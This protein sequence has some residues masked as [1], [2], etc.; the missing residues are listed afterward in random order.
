M[1]FGNRRITADICV[2]INKEKISR[3]NSTTFSGVVIY[4]KLNWKSLILSIRYKLSKCCAIM[5]RAS[6][7]INK[8]GMHILY[9]SHCMPYTKY[10]AEVWGNT[11]ATNNHCL[12]LLQK[13]FISRGSPAVKC[14]HVVGRHLHLAGLVSLLT[15]VDVR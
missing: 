10:C 7:L 6:S 15:R 1:I 13:S 14:R 9:Y 8:N 11:Y 12:V 3:V 2:R 5:Y 4:C